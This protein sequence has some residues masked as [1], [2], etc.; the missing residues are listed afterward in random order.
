MITLKIAPNFTTA[1]HDFSRAFTEHGHQNR[2]WKTRNFFTLDR[3]RE[4]ANLF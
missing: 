3:E 1:I 2:L 4:L